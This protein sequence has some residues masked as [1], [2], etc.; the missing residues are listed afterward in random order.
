MIQPVLS[1]SRIGT[2][3]MHGWGPGSPMSGALARMGP[4][5]ENVGW[6][7]GGVPPLHG[8]VT[9]L[10]H[11]G[12]GK[13]ACGAPSKMAGCGRDGE[14]PVNVEGCGCGG[15]CGAGAQSRGAESGMRGERNGAICDSE[16]VS[17]GRVISPFMEPCCNG[18]R[19]DDGGA[20]HGPGLVLALLPV[21]GVVAAVTSARAASS[22]SNACGIAHA[23]MI[24]SRFGVVYVEDVIETKTMVAGLH[25]WIDVTPTAN[26]TVSI[27]PDYQ[28]PKGM[29]PL[30]P[31]PGGEQPG[32][33]GDGGDDDGGDEG[34][35]CDALGA[36]SAA[37]AS[38]LTAAIAAQQ[39]CWEKPDTCDQ[40]EEE[41]RSAAS[42][43]AKKKADK[44]WEEYQACLKG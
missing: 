32:G 21:S 11:E 7:A 41:S 9:R 1:H 24:T 43:E 5:P 18:C 4:M 2:A 25:P 16:E 29:P 39:E 19:Y 15:S 10:V 44:A 14:E 17:G 36:A 38:A 35:E 3:S 27:D 6:F 23:K 31:G 34:G 28:W 37:A 30:G 26:T 42:T 33:G 40:K 22:E 12:K 8:A 20:Y 13:A